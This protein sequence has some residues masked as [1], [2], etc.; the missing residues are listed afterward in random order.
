MELNL[1]YTMDIVKTSTIIRFFPSILRPYV[2]L[3]P[4][5]DGA[6]GNQIGRLAAPDY[7]QANPA[8]HGPPRAPHPGAQGAEGPARGRVGETGAS[9][10]FLEGA[11][12]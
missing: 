4:T 1:S 10:L 5:S 7:P 6:D 9:A 2:P 12:Y 3:P 11:I 8:R